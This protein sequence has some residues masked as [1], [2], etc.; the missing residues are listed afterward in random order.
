MKL[1]AVTLAVAL[2]ALASSNHF[3]LA[4]QSAK[5][6]ALRCDVSE[7]LGLILASKKSIRC[8]FTSL[9]GR[10]ESYHGKIEKLG[11]DIGV[12]KGGILAWDVF[13]PTAGPRR[14]ALVGK[15]VGVDA[16]FAVGAGLGANILVGGSK[17]SFTLQ[18]VSVE[19]QSGLALAAGVA[20]LTL[21]SG[22]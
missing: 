20:S 6:G 17:R 14:H 19:A 11:I 7:G 5:V 4:K 13:A 21:H 10:S 8:K 9:H 12:T 1:R 16:S 18:P 2:L 15:Y 22:K 3:A